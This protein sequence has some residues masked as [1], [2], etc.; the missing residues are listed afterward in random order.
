MEDNNANTSTEDSNPSPITEESLESANPN[1]SLKDSSQRDYPKNYTFFISHASNSNETN[2]AVPPLKEEKEFVDSLWAELNKLGHNT[3]LDFKNNPSLFSEVN[4][5]A[6]RDSKY[7]IFVCSPRYIHRFRLS[8]SPEIID[9]RKHFKTL[10]DKHGIP[11][12]IPIVFGVTSFQYDNDGPFTSSDFRINSGY[13]KKK[14]DVMLKDV[15]T[16][17]LA[18][19]ASNPI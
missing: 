10:R 15:I 11:C 12:V 4:D 2:E 7:G 9:E 5:H 13:G 18:Y 1:Y 6:E 14:L 16:K 19:I 17:I 3:Y 8:L